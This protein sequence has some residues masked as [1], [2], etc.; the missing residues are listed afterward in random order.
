MCTVGLVEWG[1]MGTVG[2]LGGCVGCCVEVSVGVFGGVVNVWNGL[3]G[4]L[5]VGWCWGDW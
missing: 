2:E 5:V 1:W 3:V 4:V